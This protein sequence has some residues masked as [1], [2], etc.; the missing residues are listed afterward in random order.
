MWKNLN[1]HQLQFLPLH[2][3]HVPTGPPYLDILS[4]MA[5]SLSRLP[6]HVLADMNTH[7]IR[8]GQNSPIEL[9]VTTRLYVGL[10]AYEE[11]SGTS[12]EP[13]NELAP[14]NSFGNWPTLAFGLDEHGSIQNQLRDLS[15]EDMAI[16]TDSFPVDNIG[17]EINFDYSFNP[18]TE[19]PTLPPSAPDTQHSQCQAN[20][21]ACA[22]WTGGSVGPWAGNA[23][24]ALLPTR[25]VH[26]VPVSCIHTPIPVSRLQTPTPRLRVEASS[27]RPIR[28]QPYLSPGLNSQSR[29]PPLVRSVSSPL[30]VGLGRGVGA[31]TS[32]FISA[33]NTPPQITR[34]L[35]PLEGPNVVP[36]LGQQLASH[37]GTPTVSRLGTP[38][39]IHPS[40]RIASGNAN[41]PF[42]P[43][44]HF[45]TG[46]DTDFLDMHHREPTVED[47]D[48]FVA[49][50]NIARRGVSPSQ[51]PMEVSVEVDRVH[52]D[53]GDVPRSVVLNRVVRSS[54]P[55][56]PT[57]LEMEMHQADELE[58][59]RECR[60]SKDEAG[61][62]NAKGICTVGSY[63]ERDQS[64]MAVMR[65]HLFWDLL[66]RS[67]WSERN[68]N[69]IKRAQE[70]AS[71]VTKWLGDDIV[72]VDFKKMVRSRFQFQCCLY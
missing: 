42:T 67:P 46:R 39:N 35:S 26:T 51:P 41:P 8:I 9:R 6:H 43:S 18:I 17:A 69:L 62:K 56:A 65:A 59:L 58:K 21:Y 61:T 5:I 60:K 15:S 22:D 29:A 44:P 55:K 48:N 47:E 53:G 45:D 72:T 40:T 64:Y 50:E 66:H 12:L 19:F 13:F 16:L 32:H 1:R 70:Y 7:P 57:W 14:L 33:P 28:Y 31:P 20:E 24:A 3:L 71:K 68:I 54:K 30:R 4:V 49:I 34:P 11:P 63:S 38:V 23:N 27:Q 36:A 10:S 37:P 52:V 2:R 25:A